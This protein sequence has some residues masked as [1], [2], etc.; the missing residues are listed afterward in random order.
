MVGLEDLNQV[1]LFNPR[2]AYQNYAVA[3]N[4]TSRTL[5]TYMGTLLPKSGMPP[6][7]RPGN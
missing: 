3:V 7:V 5:Y 2:N 4:S 6:T 1:Y